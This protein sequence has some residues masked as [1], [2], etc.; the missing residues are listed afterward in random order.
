MRT[1]EKN[2]KDYG[3]TPEEVRRIKEYCQNATMEDRITLLQCAISSAPGIEIEIY[4]SLVG[5]V[6][7]DRLSK[8]RN[9]PLKK[10]DFYGYQRKTLDEYKRL[11]IL[12][13]R[14]KG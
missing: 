10:D 1:R 2:Y 13:G 7:Y 3:I 11:M 9:I 4:E 6:G 12:L 14:W 8:L 5:N